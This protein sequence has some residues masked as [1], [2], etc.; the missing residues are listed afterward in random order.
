MA[1]AVYIASTPDA[2]DVIFDGKSTKEVVL[3][4]S[5]VPGAAPV[6]IVGSSIA[7]A[8]PVRPVGAQYL[9]VGDYLTYKH[10][11]LGAD[12]N[13]LLQY[14]QLNDLSGPQAVDSSGY[15][16]HGTYSGVQFGVDGIGDRNTA[17][18][19]NGSSSYIN[20]NPGGALG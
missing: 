18:M 7:N 6:R 11:V 10:E 4:G 14:L 13:N 12:A 8:L 17:V 2:T 16:R 9:T 15:N 19:L 3:V 20:I 1:T 5:A